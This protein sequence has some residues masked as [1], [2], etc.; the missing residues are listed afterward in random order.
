VTGEIDRQRR[1]LLGGALAA[2][3]AMSGALEPSL[4]SAKGAGTPAMVIDVHT[5]MY[6]RGWQEAVHNANDPHIKLSPGPNGLDSMFYMWSNVGVLGNEMFDWDARIRKMDDAGVD[7]ALISL[8]SPNVFLA[9]REHSLKAAR[10][11]NDDFAAAAAK[12]PGRI[13]WMA[14][15]P[16]DF[17]SDALGELRR[18]KDAGA[19]G[20]CTLTNIVGTPL[21]DERYR[22]IWAEIESM[23]LP[24][25][26][27]PTL[28]KVDYGLIYPGGGG[29]LANAVGFTTE[30]TLCFGRMI[31]EGFLD[32]YPGLK[33]I[34]CHGG[35]TLPY[36]AAR[37]DRVWEQMSGPST[38]PS[39]EPPS[40]YIKHRLYYDSILYDQETLAFL[41]SYVDKDRVMYGSDYPFSLGDM[42]GILGRVNQLSPKD[43][44]AVRS[45]NALKL[46]GRASLISG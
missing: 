14:S 25:F 43:R 7:L 22:V 32:R 10:A 18:A 41:V 33:L 13:K 17:P 30:T 34:A 39:K 1:A 23:G 11:A 31:F 45:A 28:P 16:W 46:F 2:G 38:K 12:H 27:H 9:E 21:T 44:D 6:T 5:H 15:L 37:F 24:V 35:G 4:A 42:P 19:V 3:T 26:I 40:H 29:A 36:L 8:S 20:I